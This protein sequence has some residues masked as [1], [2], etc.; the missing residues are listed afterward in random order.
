VD[1]YESSD[2]QLIAAKY[3]VEHPNAGVLRERQDGNHDSGHGIQETGQ[4][5]VRQEVTIGELASYLVQFGHGKQTE[6]AAAD[7]IAEVDFKRGIRRFGVDPFS[8]AEIAGPGESNL[9]KMGDAVSQCIGGPFAGVGEV[10]AHRFDGIHFGPRPRVGVDGK[11]F[12]NAGRPAC[13]DN[14]PQSHIR[15]FPVVREQAFFYEGHACGVEVVATMAE[16]SLGNAVLQER[17]WSAAIHNDR[18]TGAKVVERTGIQNI[19]ERRRHSAPAFCG[20]RVEFA[21]VT[22]ANEKVS[23]GGPQ[24]LSYNGSSGGTV[25][26]DNSESR[27]LVQGNLLNV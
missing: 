16:G 6:A 14:K 1:D 23:I 25:A 5:G 2:W 26:A 7:R 11:K 18:A 17:D 22:A 24:E 20:E 3:I 27:A 15:Y 12:R 21:F 13:R 9:A 8:F 19:Q 10:D 4:V